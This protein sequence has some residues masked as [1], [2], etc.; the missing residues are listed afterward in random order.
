MNDNTKDDDFSKLLD[1]KEQ[2]IKF[3]ELF[4]NVKELKQDKISSKTK[5]M[6]KQL[7]KI[8]QHSASFQK[9]DEQNHT[10][11]GFVKMVEPDEVLSYKTPG[12]QPFVFKKLKNGEYIEA[13]FIDLHG[14]NIEQAY[15]LVRNF[16]IDSKENSFRCVLIIHG[17]GHNSKPKANIKSYVNHWLRQMEDVLAFHSAPIY[18]GGAGALMIILKKNTK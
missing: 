15:E 6:H 8:R 12:V 16:I 18:K 9:Q 13:D 11:C 10:S 3:K 4:D 2:D 1:A 5:L 7:A 14:K 17:K